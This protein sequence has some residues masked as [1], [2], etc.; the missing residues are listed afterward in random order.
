MFQISGK[1][2]QVIALPLRKGVGNLQEERKCSSTHREAGS[3]GYVI[4]MVQCKIKM[5]AHQIKI[6]TNLE[7]VTI[8]HYLFTCVGYTHLHGLTQ[9]QSQL[10]S[11][12][13][14]GT[15]HYCSQPCRATV[16]SC[17][18]NTDFVITVGLIQSR[19]WNVLFPTKC[20]NTL[21]SHFIF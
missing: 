20:L 6:I 12:R 10:G 21:N 7:R 9:P 8:E 15:C 13:C 11:L 2:E 4:C 18:P 3:T 14:R 17:Y 1:W 19:H 5:Q 16:S